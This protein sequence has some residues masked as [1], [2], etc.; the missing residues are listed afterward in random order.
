MTKV[1]QLFKVNSYDK[2]RV[3]ELIYTVF[4]LCILGGAVS[5]RDPTCGR[6]A[7][8]ILFFLRRWSAEFPEDVIV[9]A[10]ILIR[11]GGAHVSALTSEGRLYQQLH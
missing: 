11:F 4:M 3:L 9:L 1:A 7:S 10:I 2:Q 8:H 5:V 6:Q